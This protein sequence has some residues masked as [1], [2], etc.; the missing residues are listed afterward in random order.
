[1]L[2]PAESM[3]VKTVV[4]ARDRP[5]V[6]LEHLQVGDRNRR[7]VQVAALPL[8]DNL[9]G[10]LGVDWLKGQRLELG[11]KARSLAITRSKEDVSVSGS[12]VV[13]ARRRLGQLTIVDAD[14]SGKHISAMIDTGS[15]VSMC[16]S[17][18]R[19]LLIETNGRKGIVTTSQ[20]FR[21]ESLVGEVFWGEMLYVPFMRLGGLHMGN[22]PVVCSD[23]Q[24]FD[25]WGLKDKPA[26]AL[27]MDLLTQFD[28]VA[29]DFGRSQVRFDGAD[30]AP[31][32][33]TF[34]PV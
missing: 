13:P 8:T 10:L 2:P 12:V 25:L 11:F 9:D 17:A 22:V 21:M 34:K 6:L 16:N 24:I 3:R 15:Q 23:A 20:K 28:S 1:M 27:G 29:L 14:L 32:L 18:L 26:V 19:E 7:S 31:T 30:T 5:G 4:G 33:P